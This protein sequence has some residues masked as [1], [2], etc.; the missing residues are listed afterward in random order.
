MASLDWSV[1]IEHGGASPDPG[2]RRAAL[3]RVVV[4]E[5]VTDALDR[6]DPRLGLVEVVL[7]LAGHAAPWCRGMFDRPAARLR[8]VQRA[9]ITSVQTSSASVRR[10]HTTSHAGAGG[11]ASCANAHWSEPQAS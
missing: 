8:S 1:E 2:T 6:I 10:L 4:L 11:V 7:G 9:L 5:P 3:L